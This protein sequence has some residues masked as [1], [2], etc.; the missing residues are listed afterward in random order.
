LHFYAHSATTN[1]FSS[2]LENWNSKYSIE[3]NI[4][5]HTTN[6]ALIGIECFRLF[7]E[8]A[9][10]PVFVK[11]PADQETIE[12]GECRFEAEITGVPQPTVQW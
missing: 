8:K 7:A 12:N 1:K 5:R 3:F 11:G 6:V 2:K 10:K 9:V 4:K